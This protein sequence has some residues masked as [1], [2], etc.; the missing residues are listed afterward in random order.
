VAFWSGAGSG[1][2]ASGALAVARGHAEAALE[3]IRLFGSR[4]RTFGYD[5]EIFPGGRAVRAVRAAGHTPGH[6]AIMLESAGERLLGV[7]DSFYDPLQLSHPGW[8]T[9]WD[10][11][12]AAAASRR[13]L[14]ARAADER[15]LV[16]AYHMPFPGLGYVTRY[17]DAPRWTPAG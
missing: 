14:L 13:I 10:T 7:G 4:L 3:A 17:G 16:H 8:S 11:D 12:A 9:Q 5:D 1:A 6:T 15:L 2:N